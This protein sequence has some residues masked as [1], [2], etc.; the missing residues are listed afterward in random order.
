MKIPANIPKTLNVDTDDSAIYIAKQSI[1]TCSREL[2]RAVAIIKPEADAIRNDASSYGGSVERVFRDFLAKPANRGTQLFGALTTYNEQHIRLGGLIQPLVET[3]NARSE[4]LVAVA[5]NLAVFCRNGVGEALQ[6]WFSP[7]TLRRQ[8]EFSVPLIRVNKFQADH[9]G[10]A[11]GSDI[12]RVAGRYNLDAI[13]NPAAEV[14]NLFSHQQRHW[15]KS[16]RDYADLVR[17]IESL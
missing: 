17:F 14:L 16:V 13:D 5:T 10:L 2:T 7:E 8:V 6:K 9:H 3:G 4:A 11:F 1:E 15:E 12:E